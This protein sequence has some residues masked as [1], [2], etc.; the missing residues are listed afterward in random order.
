M[1]KSITINIS[2]LS[3]DFTVYAMDLPGHGLSGEPV[4]NYTLGF[5]TGFIFDFMQALKIDCASLVGHSG[6]AC[7][8]ERRY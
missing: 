6:Q 3:Q 1:K 7:M 2:A 5:A 4:A 8:L